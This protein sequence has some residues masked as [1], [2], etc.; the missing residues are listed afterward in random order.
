M[1]GPLFELSQGRVV[2]RQQHRRGEV[3]HDSVHLRVQGKTIEERQIDGKS[4]IPAPNFK[5]LSKGGQ[6]HSGGREA[7]LC[8]P[9]PELEPGMRLQ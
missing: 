3:S 8:S 5:H 6:Q 4:W 2:H 7:R 9:F 1:P